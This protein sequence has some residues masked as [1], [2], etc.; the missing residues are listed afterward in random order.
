MIF[1]GDN[2]DTVVNVFSDIYGLSHAKKDKLLDIV[3]H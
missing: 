1:E 3:K 2:I